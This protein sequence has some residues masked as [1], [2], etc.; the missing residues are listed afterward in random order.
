LAGVP[1]VSGS[2]STMKPKVL[3]SL[4]KS[5]AAVAPGA[6]T[7]QRPKRLSVEAVAVF[8]QPCEPAV[9]PALGARITP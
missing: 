4:R 1:L 5:C 2:I 8:D 3:G 6:D 7:F 9:A